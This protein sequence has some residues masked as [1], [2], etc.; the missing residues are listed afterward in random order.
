MRGHQTDKLPVFIIHPVKRQTASPTTQQR[1]RTPERCLDEACGLAGAIDLEIVKAQC[2]PLAT[3]RPGTLFGKGKVESLVEEIKASHAQLVVMDCAL[4]P[5]QQRNLERAW[6]VKVLDRTALILE[7][8]GDRA[9]TKEGRLQ[10]E[11][12]H[13]D[14]QR[15]RL[16]RSWTHL[17]R[18]RGGVGFL[19][20][21][22]ETQ[23]ESDRRILLQKITRLKRQLEN[24][25]RT[26]TLHRSA[27]RQVPYPVIALV[28]YTNAGKSTLFNRLTEADVHAEDLLFATLDPTMRRLELPSGAQAILSDTVG[29]ISELPTELV[30]AFGATLEE[31]LEADVIVHVRDIA[32]PDTEAQE[33]D[34]L[35]I[36]DQLGIGAGEEVSQERHMVIALN[37]ADQIDET[38]RLRWQ[39][40]PDC[41]THLI[42]A[43]TGEGVET[44]LSDLDDLVSSQRRTVSLSLLQGETQGVAMAWLYDHGQVQ[45]RLED[46]DGVIHLRIALTPPDIG[47]FEKRFGSG[48]IKPPGTLAQTG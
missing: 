6:D 20:G 36:L 26:R 21:P 47:R 32:D 33:R 34:V 23:I 12:A 41:H 2:V 7:I 38:A 27:R 19:G 30:A 25:K 39:Q 9:R 35:S 40:V 22:G 14:Y 1:A 4:T 3:V 16:V 46:E 8:F 31:V 43:L 29:F 11:L 24:V 17:E 10:V 42:S 28:G 48:L 18:Q 13:L 44:L 15:S 5:I 37:K 45:E